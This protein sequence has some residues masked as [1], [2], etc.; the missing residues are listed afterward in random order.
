MRVRAFAKINL[1]LRVL[2]TRPDGY[3][4][5][6]TVFQSIA[7]HDDLTIRQSRGPL[8]L[9]CDAADCPSGPANLVWRAAAEVWR[10]SDRSGAPRG[11]AIHLAKRIPM[12]AGLGGGSSDAAAAIRA[13]GRLWGVA[14]PRQR[15][16]AGAIGADVPYFL[17]GGTALG[18]ERG[19]LVFP[20]HDLPPA[21]ALILVPPFGVSTR[22]AF[23][24]FD[25][26]P[27]RHSRPIAT[28]ADGPD[29]RNDLEE[30]VAARHREV[31]GL[32]RVM[33]HAGARHALMSGSGS[34]VVGLFARRRT[35]IDAATRAEAG[36][37]LARVVL[38]RTLGSAAY[39][40]LARV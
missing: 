37:R 16:I 28:R 12:Q 15:A 10:A 22:D 34:G 19:D 38:T 24:W 26:R 14:R 27:R 36:F 9:T 7:L 6:R 25:R 30:V 18:L 5:L 2:G 29:W 20:L 13:L 31:A 8:T 39:R 1:S 35:A 32:V 23:H 17:E 33:R 21:W 11:V 3:H 40:R 4:E